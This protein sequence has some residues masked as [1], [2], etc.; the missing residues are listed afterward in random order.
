MARD[1]KAWL[2]DILTAI[3]DIESFTHALDADGFTADR[4]T[5]LAVQASLSH[6]GEAVKGLPPEV[7][8]RHPGVAWPRIMGLRNILVHEYFRSDADILWQVVVGPHL[9]GLRAAVVSELGGDP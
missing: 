6:I 7:R 4:K 9:T 2:T 1:G 5:M 3:E 8:S